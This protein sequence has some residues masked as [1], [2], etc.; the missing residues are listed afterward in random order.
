MPPSI[1]SNTT[2]VAVFHRPCANVRVRL[3]GWAAKRSFWRRGG[4]TTSIWP[5]ASSLRLAK[6]HDGSWRLTASALR[7]VSCHIDLA[8]A[9]SG[10]SACLSRKYAVHVQAPAH[11]HGV[12]RSRCYYASMAIKC[13]LSWRAMMQSEMHQEIREAPCLGWNP[14][15]S[16]IDQGISDGLDHSYSAE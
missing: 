6:Q 5:G 3:A 13:P 7:C 4:Q 11:G 16:L 2:P 8:W 12:A 15:A 9:T 14:C 10:A 1:Q